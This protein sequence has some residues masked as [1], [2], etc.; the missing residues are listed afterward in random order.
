M[1]KRQFWRL[2]AEYTIGVLILIAT[3]LGAWFL[4]EVYSQIRDQEQLSNPVLSQRAPITFLDINSLDIAGRMQLLKEPSLALYEWNDE[5]TIGISE[6]A[7]VEKA[8]RLLETW[9]AYEI[10]PEE[11]ETFTGMLKQ[12]VKDPNHMEANLE[13]VVFQVQVKETVFQVIAMAVYCEMPEEMM[14]LIMDLDKEM[15]YYVSMFGEPIW[16][17]MAQRVGPESYASYQEL[18]EAYAAG[19]TDELL[20]FGADKWQNFYQV[21]GA[22]SCEPREEQQQ[23]NQDPETNEIN[24]QMWGE[25]YGIPELDPKSYREFDLH[26]ENFDGYAGIGMTYSWAYGL[27]MEVMLGT[28]AWSMLFHDDYEYEPLAAAFESWLGVVEETEKEAVYDEVIS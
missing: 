5:N 18:K 19:K 1:K 12:A 20:Y 24:I 8:G 15:L 10:L 22:L 23:Q 11:T 9:M 16:N 25:L 26:Y 14:F 13:A 27:G 21:C 7:I 28:P 4:P 17:E 2:A 6:E 3:V